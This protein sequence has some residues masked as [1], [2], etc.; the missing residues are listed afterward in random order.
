M[1]AKPRGNTCSRKRRRNSD[2][3]ELHG[4]CSITIGAVAPAERHTGAVDGDDA[5]IA[6]R[7]AMGVTRQVLQHL[8]RPAERWLAVDDPGLLHQAVEQLRERST[9]AEPLQFALESQ[10]A[11]LERRPQLRHEL[12][13]EHRA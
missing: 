11:A 4:A 2:A 9:L 13:A 3:L 7:D 6:D 1:R 8:H 10:F 12:A 5:S